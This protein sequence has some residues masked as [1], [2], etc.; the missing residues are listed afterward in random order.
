MRKR[1]GSDRGQFVILAAVSMSM[2]MLIISAQVYEAA[3]VNQEIRFES[4]K[5]IVE[6]INSDYQNAFTF[7]LR[8]ATR[9]K[10][11]IFSDAEMFTRFHAMSLTTQLANSTY[12]N[13]TAIRNN[14]VE[15]LDAWA[16]V[17]KTALAGY[18]VSIDINTPSI[19]L[20]YF[21]N[22]EKA[23]SSAMADVKFN[24]SRIGLTGFR[25]THS[26]LLQASIDSDDLDEQ[27]S[28]NSTVTRVT[29]NV[30]R[31]DG[32]PI[33]DLG[34]GSFA[35]YN[36]NSSNYWTARPLSQVIYKGLGTYELRLASPA[37]EP[38][39][40]RYSLLVVSD[41]RGVIVLVSYRP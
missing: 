33:N 30:K 37:V 24:V 39:D 5:E 1:G 35:L 38:N 34:M 18:G 19:T 3:N 36:L 27:W 41:F 16:K 14:A 17:S 22:S 21:W 23:N 25:G 29:V 26:L 15:F 40:T 9:S 4:Y 13:N 31:V 28:S 10:A 2:V 12:G 11:N 32:L 7:V 6:T 20:R 8:N